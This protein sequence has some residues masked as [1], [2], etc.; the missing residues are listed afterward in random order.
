MPEPCIAK[1][2]IVVRS[3]GGC[4]VM[5]DL[6]EANEKFET[7]GG[8]HPQTILNAVNNVAENIRMEIQ[9][10]LVVQMQM[11]VAAQLQQ[12]EQSNKIMA[13]LNNKG[14]FNAKGGQPR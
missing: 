3:D 11:G 10:N 2:A 12:A 14:G 8:L 6:A 1:F 13:A 7:P 9:A 5:E 4:V